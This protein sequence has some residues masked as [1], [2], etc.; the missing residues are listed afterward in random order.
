MLV[1][2]LLVFDTLNVEELLL[3]AEPLVALPPFLLLLLDAFPV[4]LDC[5]LLFV[6]L[7]LLLFVV[8]LLLP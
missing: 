1:E 7:V 5:L 3:L 8:V 4:E 2:V 6:M